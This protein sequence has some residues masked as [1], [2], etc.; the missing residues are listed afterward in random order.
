LRSEPV[1]RYPDNPIMSSTPSVKPNTWPKTQSFQYFRWPLTLFRENEALRSP[2]LPLD[3]KTKRTKYPVRVLRYWWILSV[4]EEELKARGGSATI[5]D[6]GC[7][8]AILKQLFG[9]REGVRF[10]GMDMAE[11][12]ETN[13]IDVERAAYDELVVGDLDNPIPL[14]DASVDIVVNSHV[15]E[16]LPRPDFTMGE[17]ARI[18]RPGG[19]LLLGF[20]VLPKFFAKIREKQFAKEIDAGDRLHWQHQ[21]AFSLKSAKDLVQGAGL[22]LEFMLGTHLIR[23]RG[24]FWENSATLMRMNQLWGMMLPALGRELCV[25]ARKPD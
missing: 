10:L 1:R 13:K 24:A 9:Q 16:H 12:F 8:R 25:K 22:D 21:N 5:A 18:L 19:V 7:D 15:M 6:I 17:I 2:D 4:I 23:K 3:K 11:R 20:P 14:P